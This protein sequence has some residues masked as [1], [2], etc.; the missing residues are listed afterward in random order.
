MHTRILTFKSIEQLMSEQLLY[1]G[2]DTIIEEGVI[3]CHP[4]RDGRVDPVTIGANGIIRSGT[5]IY[6]GVKMGNNCQTGHHVVIRENTTIGHFSVIGTGVKCEM[7][8]RIG[9][10]VLIETQSH[11]TGNMVIEDYVFVG[12]FV[13]TTND[14]RMIWMREGERNFEGPTLRFGCRIGSGAI[15][16]PGITVGREAMVGAGAVVTRDVPPFAIALGVPARVVGEVPADERLDGESL[17]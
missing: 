10:H 3:L 8:T 1:L 2:D 11:I 12:G 15:L 5:I 7:D 4:T 13:G 6:S 14:H 17:H 16:L 9:N